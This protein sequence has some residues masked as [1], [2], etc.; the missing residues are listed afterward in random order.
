MGCLQPSTASV[1]PFNAT[2]DW[3]STAAATTHSVECHVCVRSGCRDAT[4]YIGIGITLLLVS[5]VFWVVMAME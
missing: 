3:L 4:N 2:C 1:L 5:G